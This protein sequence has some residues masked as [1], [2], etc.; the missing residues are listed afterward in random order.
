MV[1]LWGGGSKSKNP[2]ESIVPYLC[3]RCSNLQNF[4]VLE[5][6]KY[7]HVYGIRIAKWNTTRWIECLECAFSYSVQDVYSFNSAKEI[8]AKWKPIL[9]TEPELSHIL[10]L[11]GDVAQSVLK[12][13]ESAKKFYE[14]ADVGEATQSNP[15]EVATELSEKFCENCQKA[16]P[17]EDSF[18]A[19]CGNALIYAAPV[20]IFEPGFS[21]Y[22]EACR[23][24]RP[25]EEV[26]CPNCGEK[27]SQLG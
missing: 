10:K 24:S 11:C 17:E 23:A 9:G 22:C 15:Q 19:E 18:C 27:L 12:D 21:K 3:S 1:F 4:A 25:D 7:G 5:H 14:L 6:Y 16:R 20:P 2:D 8:S 13:P 26:F